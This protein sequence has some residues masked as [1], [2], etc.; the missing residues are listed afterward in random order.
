VNFFQDESFFY[1][2]S[3]RTLARRLRG[4]QAPAEVTHG[5]YES[6]KCPLQL[7]EPKDLDIYLKKRKYSI[8]PP[9]YRSAG[10]VWMVVI[11]TE[12]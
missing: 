2:S 5:A 12:S 1:L 11:V 4:S 3:G 8:H 6:P 10:S 7:A 9:K